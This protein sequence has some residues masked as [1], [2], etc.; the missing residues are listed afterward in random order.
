MLLFL[1][2]LLGSNTRQVGVPF[3]SDRP[4]FDVPI[5]TETNQGGTFL[6]KRNINDGTVQSRLV[7][8]P[9]GVDLE[10]AQGGSRIPIPTIN[11]AV[12]CPR[13]NQHASYQLNRID[14]PARATGFQRVH[15]FQLVC[16]IQHVVL[17][18]VHVSQAGTNDESL[19]VVVVITLCGCCCCL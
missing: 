11:F 1:L 8:Q 2:F 4:F 14:T 15:H 19:L 13:R 9:S 6:A 18:N 17:R 3:V 7:I 10:A 16:V 12:A 5:P